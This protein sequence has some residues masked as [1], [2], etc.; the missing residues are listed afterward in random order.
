MSI[1]LVIYDQLCEETVQQ[2]SRNER[3]PL[4]SELTFDCFS[5]YDSFLGLF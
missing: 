5:T 4:A 2:N 3:F 1:Y